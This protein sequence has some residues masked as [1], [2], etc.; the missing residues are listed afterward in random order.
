MFIIRQQH[1]QINKRSFSTFKPYTLFHGPYKHTYCWMDHTCKTLINTT[2]TTCFVDESFV[3][4][5]LQLLQKAN[6]TPCE[7][8]NRC[9]L[10]LK[11]MAHETQP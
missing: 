10:L 6:L 1:F 4:L 9:T 8:I 7:V 11:D 3:R 5:Y 2:A